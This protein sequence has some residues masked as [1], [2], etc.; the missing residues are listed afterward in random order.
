MMSKKKKQDKVE[1]ILKSVPLS[2]SEHAYVADKLSLMDLRYRKAILAT[3]E[4]ILEN[5]YFGSSENRVKDTIIE[6][7][8]CQD[9]FA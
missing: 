3:L 5:L 2:K 8:D 4:L 7:K 9:Y 6:L 1:V